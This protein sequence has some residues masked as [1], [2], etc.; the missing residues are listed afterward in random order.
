MLNGFT[1]INLTKLDV[2]TGYPVVKIAT[3]YISNGKEITHMPASLSEFST[4]QVEWEELPG[5]TQDLSK[6]RSFDD[7]PVNARAFVL[8]L[9]ELIGTRIRWVGVGVGREDII[10]RGP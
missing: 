1:Y 5:W 9:E 3:K 6:V 4:V 2:L 8:R 10:D 7:L